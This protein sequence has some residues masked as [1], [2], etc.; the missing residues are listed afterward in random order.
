MNE[1]QFYKFIA[2]VA[3]EMRWEGDMLLIWIPSYLVE[4][5]IEKLEYDSADDSGYEARIQSDCICVDIADLCWQYDVD[6]EDIL[7]KEI[8]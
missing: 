1:I 3:N 8:N 6:P 4:E 7:K 5:F 2:D